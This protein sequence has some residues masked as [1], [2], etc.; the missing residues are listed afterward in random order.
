M[1]Y[2]KRILPNYKVLETSGWSSNAQCVGTGLFT[3]GINGPRLDINQV[4]R[5]LEICRRWLW[6]FDRVRHSSLVTKPHPIWGVCCMSK[7]SAWQHVAFI[8]QDCASQVHPGTWI[9]GIRR[10]A[11]YF[12]VMSSG[13]LAWSLVCLIVSGEIRAKGCLE[14]EILLGIFNK[15]PNMWKLRPKILRPLAF[16]DARQ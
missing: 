16:S 2:S 5:D 15:I 4:H 8:S 7:H 6:C 3:I 13:L 1:L 14:Y 9:W 10:R 11:S 12:L